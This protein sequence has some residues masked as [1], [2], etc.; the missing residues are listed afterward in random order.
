MPAAADQAARSV[1]I[2]A[3]PG[4]ARWMVPS[5]MAYRMPPMP[6]VHRGLPSPYLT[7]VFSLADPVGI[8][9]PCGQDRVR[10]GRFRAPLGG[11]HTRPVLLPQ[12]GPQAGIQLAV[13]PLACRPLLGVP[14]DELRYQVLEVADVLGR[15]GDRL[16]DRL[17]EATTVGGAAG[18]VAVLRVWLDRRAAAEATDQQPEVSR[19]WQLI[20]GSGGRRRIGQVA[21]DVG[22]SRRHLTARL[23]SE[24][25]FGAKEL[26]RLARFHRARGAIVARAGSLAD[27]AASCGYADQSH[28]TTEWREF[29]GCSP[30]QWI[31]AE[32]PTLARL[33]AAEQH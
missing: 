2:P 8:D 10:S 13:N 25:G 18:A 5:M 22:W 27:V 3:P 12:H 19:A 29:A 21:A 9:V 1:V 11:L 31:A 4:S 6:G 30:G 20:V 32:V 24:T 17:L 14:A 33:A 28:F 23:R 7:L 15:D 26:A 16:L